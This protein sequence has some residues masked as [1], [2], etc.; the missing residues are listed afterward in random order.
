MVHVTKT[1]TR[2]HGI[3]MF[4]VCSQLQQEPHARTGHIQKVTLVLCVLCS[5]PLALHAGSCG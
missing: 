3:C 1:G 2:I 5:Q 4:R